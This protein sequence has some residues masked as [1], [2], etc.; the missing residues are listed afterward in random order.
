MNPAPKTA[1]ELQKELQALQK[2]SDDFLYFLPDALLE[3]DILAP[4]L[5]YM[6]RIAYIVFGYTEADFAEGIEISRLFAEGEYE[7]AVQIIKG[8]VA[9]SLARKVEYTR[10]GRQDLYQFRMR[11]KDG[12]LFHAETQTSFVLGEKHTPMKLRTLIR[13]ITERKQTEEILRRHQEELE[14]KVKERTA[15][16][17]RANAEL[18]QQITERQRIEDALRHREE[19]YRV[20]F[21]DNP[22]MYFTVDAAGQ[23]LAVNRF[24]AEQ[25]GYTVDELLGQPVLK[26]FYEED[27]LPVQNH[28][29]TCLQNPKKN[30][31]WEFRKVRKDGSLL[32]VKESARAVQDAEG[33]TIVLIVCEDI[34]ETKNLQQR[35]ERNERLAALGQLSATI[36]HEIRNPLGSISLNVQYLS[37]RLEIPDPH[38]KTLQSIKQGIIRIQNIINGILD[39]SRPTPPA[40]KKTNLHKVLDSSLHST[41]HELEQA[42][43]VISKNYQATSSEAWLDANLMGQVFVNLYLNAKEAMTPGGKLLIQTSSG[44]EAIKVQ[45]A[46]TGRGILPEHLKKIYDPFFTT[47]PDGSGLGLAV[48]AR[49]LEQHH[50]QIFVESQVNTGTKF[51]IVLPV[52]GE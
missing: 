6:N 5:T 26:V 16:L 12:S 37:G 17:S 43:I 19:Q 1:A 42:G 25:L 10:S 31:H 50:G 24:G 4:R 30:F 36:A 44:D 47:K 7:R 34:T 2:Q 27:R 14:S 18:E 45:I 41:R 28:L 35:A 52:A 46:D 9:D 21:E 13:D 8:Y 38:K 49:I 33:K 29:A 48:V 32:W 15:E 40:M 11:R 23:V 3:V 51:T 39:F 22:T 20:L